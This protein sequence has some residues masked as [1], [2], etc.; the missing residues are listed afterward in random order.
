[1]FLVHL[2]LVMIGQ[3]IEITEV[4]QNGHQTIIPIAPQMASLMVKE[5]LVQPIL[6]ETIIIPRIYNK[7]RLAKN[8]FKKYEQ[9]FQKLRKFNKKYK[10]SKIEKNRKILKTIKI[11]LQPSEQRS[12]SNL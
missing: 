6:V 3:S 10:K 11:Y 9:K 12:S 4:T 2:N 1:M 5:Q 7:V 8:N